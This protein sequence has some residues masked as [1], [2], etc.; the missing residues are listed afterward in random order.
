V[1]RVRLDTL[2]SE[3]GAFPSR[4]SAAA[5]VLAGE[6]LLLPERRP[7][8]KPGQL[9]PDD[10]QVEVLKGPEFV[11]RGGIKLANALYSFP[12]RVAGRRALDIGSS[13]GGFTDCLLQRGALAVVCVDVGYGQ[14]DSRL[15]NDPRVTVIERRNARSLRPEDLPY[16]PEVIVIDVSFISV[17][18]VLPAALRCAAPRFDCVAL[19]K[20]QFE[21]GRE[22][23]GSGGVVREAAERRRSLVEVGREARRLGSAVLGYASSGLPGPK[24]NRETFA[25]LAEGARGGLGDGELEVAALEVEP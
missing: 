11:S 15:R 14:L 3:R 5:S 22:R 7:A 8:A 20:P 9:V 1:R 2:L 25:W 21:V 6:V 16:A 4:S 10:V 12:L 18:K 13:T 17:R 19:V 24:G 23:V